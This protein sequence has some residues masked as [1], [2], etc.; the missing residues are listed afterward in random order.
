MPKL[1]VYNTSLLSALSGMTFEK[2]Y[3]IPKVWGRWVESAVGAHILNSAEMLDYK[4]YYWRKQD[5][6]V[7]FVIEN[8][9]QC[10]AI[11]VKSG[12][13][14]TNAGLSAFAKLFSPSRSFVVGSG[15]VPVEEFLQWNLGDLFSDD[16]T[17]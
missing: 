1:F 3:T 13:R 14:T 15:G 6:E 2:V 5:N 9:R 7:D 8:N 16:F 12:R 10:I 17:R 11:E 4:V